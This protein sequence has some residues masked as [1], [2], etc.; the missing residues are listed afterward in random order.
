M[1][2][3]RFAINNPNGAAALAAEL[4]L[5]QHRNAQLRLDR[6]LRRWP[7]PAAPTATPQYMQATPSSAR[8]REDRRWPEGVAGELNRG[9]ASRP[10]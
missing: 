5:A 2:A 8:L 6:G 1:H 3:T 10:R 4:R 9:F 7:A